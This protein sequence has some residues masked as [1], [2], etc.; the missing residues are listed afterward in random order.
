MTINTQVFQ[1]S[2]VGD[3]SAR[4]FSFSPMVIYANDELEVITTVIATGVETVISKGSSSTT[5][6]ISI[7]DNGFPDTGSIDYPAS[8]GT[9]LPSTER[10]SIRRLLTI[11]NLTDLENQGGYNAEVQERQYDKFAAILLQQ[12]EELNRCLKF[13]VS[14]FDIDTDLST[15]IL[16]PLDANVGQFLRYNA[17][18]DK[19]DLASVGS[20]STASASDA[21]PAASSVTAGVA[22]SNSPYS[23]EDHVHLIPTTVPR[24]AT[25]NIWTESQ[26]WLKGSDA[27][28]ADPLVL[29]AGNIFD[30]TGTTDIAAITGIGVG[31]V[32]ILHFDGILTLTASAADL[33]LPGGE[34]VVTFAGYEIMLYEYAASDWRFVCDNADIALFRR[35]SIDLGAKVTLQT[36]FLGDTLITA[37]WN[38]TA[39]GGTGN[40]VAMSAGQGG[41]YSLL[42]SSV[43]EGATHANGASGISSAALNWRADAG[44]LVM[45]ARI[46]V[47]DITSVAIFVGFT[48]VES[49]T[50]ELPIFLVAGNIDSDATNACGVGFDTDGSTAEW[51]HGGV[52]ADADTTPAFSSSAPSNDTYVTIRVEVSAAGAV[53]GYIDGVAIGAAVASA[54]TATTPLTPVIF[55]NQRAAS[56]RTLLVDYIWVSSDR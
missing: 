9:L 55:V 48:D 21:T 2:A 17:A 39:G 38:A 45:E 56:A 10:I 25:E 43:D 50:V 44:G 37:E 42:T 31:T 47:D 8:G 20:S 24:L 32:I 34:D 28:S 13:P 16:T 23:R 15:V 22:G 1:V 7:A 6:S 53:R 26:V 29:A 30:V 19:F 27:S 36:D 46:Q 52:K 11:E 54:V 40:A 51:F 5:Y 12:Q 35:Q 18:G 4:T 14:V 41:R 3:G 49:T 33:I